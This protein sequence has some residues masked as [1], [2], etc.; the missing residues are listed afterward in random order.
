MRFNIINQGCAANFSEGEQIAGI[1]TLNGFAAEAEATSDV[2]I[3]NLCTVKGNGT[4]LKAVRETIKANPHKPLVVTGCVTNDLAKEI[5]KIDHPISVTSTNDMPEIAQIVHKTVAGQRI[6]HLRRSKT[7]KVGIPKRRNNPVVGIL[8]VSNGCLDQCT[9]CSTRLVKGVHYS[10]PLDDLVAE[11]QTLVA[12][13]CHEI[14]LT[15]QDCGC[16]GFDLGLNITHLIKAILQAIPQDFRLRIGMGN[17]RHIL[18][19]WEDLSEVF[20]DPRVFRFIH[21]PVQSGSNKVLQ[22]MGRIHSA[23]DFRMLVQAL[24]SRVPDLTI[25]TDIIVGFP[26]E[27]SEDFAQ[28]LEIVQE[29]Q[30]VVCNITRFVVRAGTAAAKLKQTVVLDEKKERSRILSAQFMAQ[31]SAQN[32]AL[33]GCD[34]SVLVDQTGKAG[35][36]VAHNDNFRP[37]V[38]RGDYHL[39]QRLDVTITDAN[40]FSLFGTAK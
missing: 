10:Y 38:L 19:F 29:M 4:A 15:G 26:G 9:F 33:I 7:M 8:A 24:R 14:W 39:G 36:W 35:D 27:T 25:S 18:P 22:A 3:L 2:A 28:T 34:F 23:D 37:I 21:L 13:G 12:D 20:T 32:Q 5:Q 16:W 6:E 30:P 17:P 1:L 11:A 31:S 40:A